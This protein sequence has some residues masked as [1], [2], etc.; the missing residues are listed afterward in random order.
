MECGHV[1]DVLGSLQDNDL[2]LTALEA[3]LTASRYAFDVPYIDEKVPSFSYY[4][5]VHW[6]LSLVLCFFGISTNLMHIAVLSPAKMRKNA[7][8]RLVTAAI[9]QFLTSTLL[10]M[11]F[12]AIC[13]ILT[14]ALYLVFVTYFGSPSALVDPPPGF[15]FA[16][17]LF[18]L[19]YSVMSVAL[20]AITLY[21][22]VAA[23]YIRYSSI[24]TLSN[25]WR[26][27]NVTG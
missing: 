18:M 19:C 23:A 11:I 21:A 8:N 3:V 12:V 4:A 1:D 22:V 13:D 2:L 24:R 6:T 16:W 26:Y 9:W 15:P 10:Q 17:T 25:K 14:M 20:H 27:H 5:S 7:V